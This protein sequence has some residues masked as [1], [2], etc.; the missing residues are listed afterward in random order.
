M[1]W[2]R[3]FEKR[4]K[5]LKSIETGVDILVATPGRLTDMIE[6]SKI[7]HKKIKFERLWSV[8][9]SDMPPLDRIQTMLFSA[10]FPFKIQVITGSNV[11]YSSV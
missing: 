5:Q 8:R 6:R 1:G 2:C 4:S 7:S 11:G 9:S 3:K 10:N